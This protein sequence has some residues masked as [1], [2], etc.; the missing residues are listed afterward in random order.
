MY[1]EDW[2]DFVSLSEELFRA[3]PLRVRPPLVLSSARAC[4]SSSLP[5][6]GLIR[7]LCPVARRRASA[8]NTGTPTGYWSS[9]SQTTCGCVIGGEAQGFHAGTGLSQALTTLAA[10]LS[11]HDVSVSNTRQ[12]RRQTCESW[13]S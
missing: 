5:R 9:K 8:Q 13:R 10:A 12:T 11:C 2:Q 4:R 7:P 1:V 3:A 6:R